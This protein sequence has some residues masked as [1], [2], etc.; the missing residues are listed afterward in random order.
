MSKFFPIVEEARRVLDEHRLSY[1]AKKS[2]KA[3][4]YAFPKEKKE[5]L[6]DPGH[7]RDAMARF[8]QVKGVSPEERKSAK[9]KIV[10]K[11]KADGIKL[12]KFK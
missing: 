6:E 11:A 1:K 2:M 9:K 8:N 7:V 12:K 4:E 10:A 5:P 3:G